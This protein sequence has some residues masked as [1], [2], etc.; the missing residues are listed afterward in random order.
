[1]IGR[2]LAKNIGRIQKRLSPEAPAILVYHRVF[3]CEHDIWG[4]NTPPAQ[5]AEQIE[6]LQSVRRVLPLTDLLEFVHSGRRADRPLAAVTFDDGYHDVFNTALPILERLDCPATVFVVSG[7]ID[8]KREFWWDELAFILTQ[9]ETLPERLALTIGDRRHYWSLPKGD[10][11]ARGEVCNQI[12][13][14]L[15]PLAPQMIEMQLEALRSWAGTERAARSS[16]RVMSSDELARLSGGPVTVGAHTVNHPS[17]P[18]LDRAA[19]HFE[20][21]EGRRALERIVGHP[22]LNFAY[23]YGHYDA[24]SVASARGSQLASACTILPGTVTRGSDHLRLP[25][26]TPGLGDGEVLLRAV[27]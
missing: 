22:V 9:T 3:D 6:A 12:R 14:R 7:L 10:T 24:A 18:A 8:A 17:L 4:L 25:R 1:V 15:L 5:L 16:H 11:T 13:R 21:A 26:I 19:Q 20:I 23:P 2:G 27:A